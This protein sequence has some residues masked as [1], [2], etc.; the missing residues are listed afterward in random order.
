MWNQAKTYVV[1]T[2]TN[3]VAM[4]VLVVTGI[5]VLSLII[6]VSKGGG[7][8]PWLSCGGPIHAL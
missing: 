2:A 5:M 8:C 7:F 3:K 6:G 1:K 4:T